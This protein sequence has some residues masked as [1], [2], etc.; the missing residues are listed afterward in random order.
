[1]N[2]EARQ[3]KFQ[4]ISRKFFWQLLFLA[5]C[6]VALFIVDLNEF[7]LIYFL[8]GAEGDSA[9][10]RNIRECDW[11]F[12]GPSRKGKLGHNPGTFLAHSCFLDSGVFYQFFYFR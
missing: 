3:I 2:I 12:N 7:C 8:L 1:V 5:L 10:T 9:S 6:F 4:K 11:G